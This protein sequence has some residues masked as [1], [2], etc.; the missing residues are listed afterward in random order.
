MTHVMTWRGELPEDGLAGFWHHGILCPDKSVI[1]YGGVN[2]LKTLHNAEIICTT[3]EEFTAIQ[4]RRMHVV[5]YPT[6]RTRYPPDEIERRAMS[7]IG[8]R[9][10]NLL[11]R[12][13]ESFSRWCVTGESC[14][15]QVQG[16]A[17]GIVGGLAALVCGGG[18][19]GA[20][21][22]AVIAQRVWDNG[23]NQSGTRQSLVLEDYPQPCYNERRRG[24]QTSSKSSHQ[25]NR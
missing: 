25:F 4:E 22:V 16:A 23:R 9:G 2:G 19:F 17:V 1:H 11:F 24:S 13:C 21:M 3:S 20:A 7:Q 14:S 18:P 15:F 5:E 6:S 8:Q 10:Y 12:N